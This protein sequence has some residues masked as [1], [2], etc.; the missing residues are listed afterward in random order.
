MCGLPR[1]LPTLF[2]FPIAHDSGP[3]SLLLI[4]AGGWIGYR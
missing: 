4:L 2:P 3:S 1:T